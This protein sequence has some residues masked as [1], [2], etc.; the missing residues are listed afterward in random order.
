MTRGKTRGGRTTTRGRWDWR[1]ITSERRPSEP[2][3]GAALAGLPEHALEKRLA[4]HGLERSHVLAAR[5][6]GAGFGLARPDHH[7]VRDLLELRVADL[8]AELLVAE[9]DL[10]P[11][12]ALP[13]HPAGVG[14][15]VERLGV[16]RDDDGLDGRHP[17]RE[18]PAGVLDVDPHE[19]LH[20]AEQRAVDHDAL[21]LLAVASGV[22]DAE[23]LGE[24]QVDLD[25]GTLPLAPDRV[26][27]LAVDLGR[28]DGSPPF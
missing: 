10:G 5:R 20:R 16:G 21:V 24:V 7:H 13:Q 23:A 15:V 2:L 8:G 6:D 11:D 22:G 12:A 14:G 9:V 26:L 3:L 4:R 25:G 28:I 1:W 18:L 17:H 19:A 27:E